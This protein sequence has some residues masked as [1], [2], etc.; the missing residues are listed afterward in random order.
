MTWLSR[1]FG[2]RNSMTALREGAQA[3][4]FSL[5]KLDG[6]TFS[7]LDE[8]KQ[9][10]IVLAFFKISCPVCQYTF[11]FLERLHREYGGQKLA[12][13]GVSQDDKKDTARFLSEYGVTFPAI[14]DDPATYKVSNAYGLTNVPTLFLI[15]PDGEIRLTSVGWVRADIEQINRKLA[16]ANHTSP[17]RL[18][19][20]GDDVL[21]ARPG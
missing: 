4:D 21:D 14:L 6:G 17:G 19:R 11:P 1:L 10:A 15:S 13:V 20:P 7:L 12:M 3:P 8:L 16:E 18:F 5:P 2:E 9:R